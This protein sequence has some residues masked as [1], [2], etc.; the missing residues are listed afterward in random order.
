LTFDLSINGHQSAITTVA[1]LRHALAPFADEAFR[2][3]WIVV[4]DGPA[5]SALFNG[6]T[7]WLMYLRKSGDAGFSS[8]NPTYQGEPAAVLEYR[9]SNGQIDAYP[10]NWAL[11]E[12]LVIKA[13]E[14]FVEFRDRPPFVQWYDHNRPANS[15]TAYRSP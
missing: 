12:A 4:A 10:T 15:P 5:L 2:E 14:H 13:L 11:P 3:V 6:H 8:R 7:G 9:L 1:G